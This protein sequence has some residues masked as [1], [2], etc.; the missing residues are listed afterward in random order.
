MG[1]KSRSIR[2]SKLKG[3]GKLPDVKNPRLRENPLTADRY[4]PS[5]G[6][7]PPTNPV[8]SK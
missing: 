7:L 2:R 5:I 8:R 4:Y 3:D 1:S 6:K